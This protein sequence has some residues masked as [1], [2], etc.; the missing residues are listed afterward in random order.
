[1]TG[2]LLATRDSWGTKACKIPASC[3][4]KVLQTPFVS[5]NQTMDYFRQS[6]FLF[7]PQV[8]DASP[9]V[10]TQA[11]T[12]NV[13]VL[14]NRNIIGGWKYINDKTGEFFHDMSDLRKSIDI[15][16]A[17]LGSYEPRK[18]ITENYGN[19]LYGKKLRAFV[20][21]HFSERVEFPQDSTRLI[22]S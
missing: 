9:R 18:Y 2:V 1:M 3:K 16:S 7:I 12:L 21:A 15:L 10:V 4:G 5:F 17:N 13:P 8:Y 19:E 11:M 14:M 6:R 22:P 20:E